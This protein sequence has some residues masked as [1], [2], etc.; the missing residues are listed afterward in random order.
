MCGICGFTGHLITSDEILEHMMNKIIHRGPDSGGKYMD[1]GIAMGFRRLSFRGL[2]ANGN[3]PIYNENRDRKF[4][5]AS[6]IMRLWTFILWGSFYT[7]F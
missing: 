2:S 7:G 1:E 6:R 4:T 5:G 3:Q